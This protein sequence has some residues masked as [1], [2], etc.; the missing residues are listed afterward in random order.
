MIH[1]KVSI[2]PNSPIPIPQQLRTLVLERIREGV[3]KAG[4]RLPSERALAESCGISRTSVRETIKELLTEGILF[5]TAGRGTF[6][7]QAPRRSA[8]APAVRQIGFWISAAILNFVQPGYSR[9]LTGVGEVCRDRGYRVQFHA[10]DESAGSVDRVFAGD[11]VTGGLDGN[12]VVGG[13]S[14]AVFDRLRCLET[15]LIAVD[16]L[17]RDRDTDT[18]RIDYASGTRQAVRRLCEL[19]HREI[20]FIGFAGS[21]KYE[22]FWQALE[23]CGL[24]YSPRYT[25][26]LSTTDLAP[27]ML[28][29]FESTQKMIE[30]GRL[31]TAL[32]ATNDNVALGVLQALAMAGIAVPEEFSV[33]GCDDLGVGTP[34]LT[35]IKVDLVGVGH[36]AA[37]ALLDRIEKGV[38]PRGQVRIP[39]ELVVRGTT[40]P[41]PAATRTGS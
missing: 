4:E 33:I 19:G 24:A 30:S 26:F 27:G 2:D 28:A 36:T 13:V 17:L 12:L 29:G 32:L 37:H 7:S 6:V 34:A 38:E 10:V 1:S 3:Y 21:E 5:R 23:E 41:P 11:D 25:R 35:T 14:R 40:A 31:P 39:V 15:P 9:I 16:L 22:A 8:G 20:G 18:V